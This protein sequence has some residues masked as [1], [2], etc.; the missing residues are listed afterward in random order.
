MLSS[1]QSL[2]DTQSVSELEK[3][4][5]SHEKEEV[6]DASK[7]GHQATPTQSG[8][9][10]ASPSEHEEKSGISVSDWTGEDDPDNPHNCK[11]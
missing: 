3:G 5:L 11:K 1:T 2:P 6:D 8:S 4:T 7:H 10:I 9:A